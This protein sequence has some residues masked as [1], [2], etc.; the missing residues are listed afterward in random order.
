M[1]LGATH[2]EHGVGPAKVAVRV[3]GLMQPPQQDGDTMPACPVVPLMEQGFW[4]LG[5]GRGVVSKEEEE[6]KKQAVLFRFCL[7]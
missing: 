3:A 7:P 4:H 6:K 5:K 1:G 2:F